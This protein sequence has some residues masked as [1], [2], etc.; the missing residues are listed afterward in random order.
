MLIPRWLCN[1]LL[2]ASL[3]SIAFAATP[4]ARAQTTLESPAVEAQITSLIAQMT[5]AEKISLCHA[6]AKF[7]VAGIPRLGIPSL[8]LSDGPH[9]VREELGRNSWIP[10]GM[11][12]DAGTYLPTG[13]ALAATWNVELARRFGEVLGAEARARKKDIILGPGIN[14]DRTPLGG[15]TFEYYSEDPCLISKMVVPDI[16]GIQ[17]QDTAACVKHFALNNQELDRAHVDVEVDERALREIYLP[18]FRAAVEQ[19]GA[20]AVMGAYNRFRGQPICQSP[21][22]IKDILDG[23]WH[24]DGVLMTDWNIAGLQTVPAALAGLDLEMGTNG[25]YEKYRFAT[26]LLDAVNAGQAPV[27]IIDEKVRRM[28]RLMF[29]VHLLGGEP[30]KAGS[31]NTPEHQQTARDVA[32]EAMVLLKNNGVLPLDIGNIKTLAVIGENATGY[33]F[34]VENPATIRQMIDAAVAIAAKADAVLVFAGESHRYDTEGSDRRD[35]DLHDHQN[36]LID[37]VLAANPKTAVFLIGGSPVAMPWADKAPAIVWTW[38]AGMEAGNVMADIAFGDVNPSG[39][40]PFTMPRRLA[41]TPAEV[42]G[43]YGPTKE[44]YNEG[45]LVGYRWY[46]T[47]KIDPLFCFGHGLSYTSF[48]YGD[49]NISVPGAG[50]AEGKNDGKTGGADTANAAGDVGGGN[51]TASLDVTNTG[52]RAGREVVQLYVAVANSKIER[53]AKELKAF[54]K[55]M[56]EPGKTARVQL[57]LDRKDLA[58]YDVASDSWKVEPADYQVLVGSS[59]RDIRSAGKFT[60]P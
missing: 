25:P 57:T 20:W 36:E 35:I 49:L 34:G 1:G 4:P 2:A 41:D 50:D 51:I 5:L 10:A 13:S 19:A 18:G 9:G 32:A 31:Y 44:R 24:F 26:P 23:D 45:L 48:K 14:I 6:N 59:S 16:Q 11:K 42:A 27:S 38:Y 28:L 7:T 15:R 58:Y 8:T 60:I 29:R 21:H 43:E 54:T 53:P 22:L 40:L 39:K 52:R 30:R 3:M 46:D 55:I 47:K 56:I 17:S 37:A 33:A 12:N